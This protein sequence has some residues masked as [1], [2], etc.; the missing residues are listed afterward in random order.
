[1]GETLPLERWFSMANGETAWEAGRS[2]SAG[3]I[4]PPVR[5]VVAA[6]ETVIKEKWGQKPKNREQVQIP[7]TCLV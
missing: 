4:Y 1:M 3:Q 5:S 6:M 7:S 2:E